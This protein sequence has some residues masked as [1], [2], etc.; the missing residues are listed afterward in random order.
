MTTT[1]E[2]ERTREQAKQLGQRT[3]QL[4]RD[5]ATMRHERAEQ[6]RLIHLLEEKLDLCRAEN[7]RLQRTIDAIT[8][9]LGLDQDD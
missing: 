4:Q 7:E 1:T 5:L 2:L 6:E 3:L 9:A 8:D